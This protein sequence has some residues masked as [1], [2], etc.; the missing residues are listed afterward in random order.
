MD[1][2]KTDR[3]QV[4]TCFM[5]LVSSYVPTYL[6]LSITYSENIKTDRSTGKEVGTRRYQY[7]LPLS[8]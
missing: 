1:E 6:Y 5:L 8:S 4:G 2:Q 3:S 7:L